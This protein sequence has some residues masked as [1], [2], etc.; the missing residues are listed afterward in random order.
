MKAT[1]AR[2]QIKIL[3]GVTYAVVVAVNFAAN[4]LPLNGVRTGDVSEAYPSLFTPAGL[5]FS[6]WGVIYLLLGLHVLYQ[7]GFFHSFPERGERAAMLDKVGVYF[8][9]SSIANAAWIFAW[10]YEAIALSAVLSLVILGC[11]GAITKTVLDAGPTRRERLLVGIPF[12]VYFGWATIATVA[13]IT[14]LLVSLRWDGF[15]LADS[16]WMVIVLLLAT[17]IG[18]ATVLRNRD[19]AYGLVLLWAYAGI[20]IKHVSAAGFDGRY[21][22]IIATVI[23]CLVILLAATAAVPVLRRSAPQGAH[24]SSVS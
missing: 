1:T 6:I 15:G 22:G 9:V 11:L 13:N 19:I 8:S 2:P 23:V 4:A 14:V 24:P 5:T 10:H 12:S 16:T 21:P 18:V 20:L 17:A 3:V 7:F